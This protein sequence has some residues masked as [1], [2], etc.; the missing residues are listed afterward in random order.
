MVYCSAA[1]RVREDRVRT[2]IGLT[3]LS[4]LTAPRVRVG[5]G[6]IKT[7][8]A[9]PLTASFHVPPKDL[10]LI[11]SGIHLSL[12]GAIAPGSSHAASVGVPEIGLGL[13]R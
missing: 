4:S 8:V 1:H 10:W 5:R 11:F 3:T 9:V 12:C 2:L 7:Q 13:G 6:G